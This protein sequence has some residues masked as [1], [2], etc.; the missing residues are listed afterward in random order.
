[1]LN[2][3][4]TGGKGFLGKHVV[5]ALRNRTDHSVTVFDRDGWTGARRPEW[6]GIIHLAALPRV[7][8]CEADPMECIRSNVLLTTQMLQERF[9]WFVMASTMTG[10]V[11]YYGISKRICETL[12]EYECRKKGVA[13]RILRFANITGQGENQSKLMPRAVEYVR[14]GTPFTLNN[15]ALP[16]EYVCLERAVNEIMVESVD[17]SYN[18]GS[19]VQPRKI[20]D[21]VIRNKTQLMNWA[22]DVVYSDQKAA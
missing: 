1:M 11:N 2:V 10:P 5:A 3:L 18:N 22:R 19:V 14:N 15:G 16:L 6:D 13:L 21:G 17:C 4:V 8:D 20:V 9:Q 7:S 12:A